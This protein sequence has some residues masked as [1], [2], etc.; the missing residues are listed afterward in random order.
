MRR[1]KC[2]KLAKNKGYDFND[3]LN[4]FHVYLATRGMLVRNI[5]MFLLPKKG[6]FLEPVWFAVMAEVGFYRGW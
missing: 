1:G 5:K 3:Q 2:Y 6:S 4:I